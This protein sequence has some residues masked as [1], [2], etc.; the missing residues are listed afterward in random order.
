M[1]VGIARFAVLTGGVC[2]LDNTLG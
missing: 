2:A 1:S